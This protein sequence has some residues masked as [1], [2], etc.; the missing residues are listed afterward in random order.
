MSVGIMEILLLFMVFMVLG[1]RRIANFFQSLGRGVHDFVDNLG[2]NKAGDEE[3]VEPEE[4]PKKLPA[5]ER[6]SGPE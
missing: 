6:D 5:K 2:R 4:E 3:A 1:P